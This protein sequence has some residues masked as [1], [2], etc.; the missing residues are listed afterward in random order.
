MR[1]RGYKKKIILWESSI[2]G[3]NF[4]P[5]IFFLICAESFLW[6]H[7]LFL[8][9]ISRWDWEA[10]NMRFNQFDYELFVLHVCRVK[11][12]LDSNFLEKC[13]NCV[14]TSLTWNWVVI[15]E[16]GLFVR[17]RARR[18]KIQCTFKT[19]LGNQNLQFKNLI[20]ILASFTSQKRLAYLNSVLANYQDES[21]FVSD[22]ND[23][24]SCSDMTEYW[25][26]YKDSMLTWFLKK[27]WVCKLTD[28]LDAYWA[29][30][31]L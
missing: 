5:W 1:S 24:Y 22:L 12:H 10:W 19:V 8:I 29:I 3:F 16:V 21:H 6:V 15:L 9:A 7:L 17:G 27:R 2:V 28:P 4:F 25:W 31:C 26:A 20:L 23:N 18:S 13:Q 11:A 14:S 30:R